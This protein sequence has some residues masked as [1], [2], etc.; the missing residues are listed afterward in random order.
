M[1]RRILLLWPAALLFLF[2]IMAAHS[3]E[4]MAEIDNSVFG[5]PERT[6]VAF[7]HDEHNEKA[8]LEECNAC[9]HVYENG[10]I[11]EDESSEDQQCSDCHELEASGDTP[12]LM[13]AFHKNCKGCHMEKKAGPFMCGECH[14]N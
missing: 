13:N 4:D 5:S 7:A 2:L 10:V 3:Q 14:K 8:G 6:P 9:H 1:K 12:S 11:S